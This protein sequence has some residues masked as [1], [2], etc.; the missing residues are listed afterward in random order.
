MRASPWKVGLPVVSLVTIGFAGSTLLGQGASSPVPRELPERAIGTRVGP[1]RALQV[2]PNAKDGPRLIAIW[3]AQL[4]RFA[5]APIDGGLEISSSVTLK[6][7]RPNARY[8]WNLRVRTSDGDRVVFEESYRDQMFSIGDVVPGGPAF[9]E[10]L[11][12]PP[13]EYDIRLALIC[14]PEG[15]DPDAPRDELTESHL[16]AVCAMGKA[17]V[18][19]LP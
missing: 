12:L 11:K 4:D 10:A 18:P 16:R 7:S 2:D 5:A 9:R 17:V 8:H 15:M 13:G 6:D 3:D 19:L 1:I 14:I